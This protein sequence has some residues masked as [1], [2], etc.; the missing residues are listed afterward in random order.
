[1]D[2][3]EPLS[4][5]DPDPFYHNKIS[6]T[7]T[8]FIT[9]PSILVPCL[10][11]RTKCTP[12]CFKAILIG[13]TPLEHSNAHYLPSRPLP[14]SQNCITFVFHFSWVLQPSQEKLKTIFLQNFFFGA[15]GGGEQCALWEMCKW[16]F[17]RANSRYNHC[18]HTWSTK[19]LHLGYQINRAGNTLLTDSHN[20]A[21]PDR[22]MTLF[23]TER[24]ENHG[25]PSGTSM[26]KPYKGVQIPHDFSVSLP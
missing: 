6:K 3:G 14:P 20:I 10:G 19:K 26:Y 24:T 16:R 7:H 4:I 21:Y 12:L 8:L 15:G 18:L 13:I 9:T 22:L 1:M 25:L 23:K 11:Q 2:R 5:W 17:A